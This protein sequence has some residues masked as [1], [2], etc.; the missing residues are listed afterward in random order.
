[1]MV[2]VWHSFLPLADLLLHGPELLLQEVPHIGQITA[3]DPVVVD[4]DGV[5]LYGVGQDVP[6]S[7]LQTVPSPCPEVPEYPQQGRAALSAKR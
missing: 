5:L 7:P 2:P 6:M 4:G 1:M 3:I